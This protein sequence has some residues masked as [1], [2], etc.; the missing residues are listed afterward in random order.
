M[1]IQ[2]KIQ[3]QISE[4]DGDCQPPPIEGAWLRR[5][6]DKHVNTTLDVG[7]KRTPLRTGIKNIQFVYV[8][9]VAGEGSVS[10]Y[11]NLSPD[12]LKF[13]RCVLWFDVEDL[14]QLS[15]KADDDTQLYVY[16]AG[17]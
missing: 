1:A 2:T 17:E 7:K 15:F 14:H 8:R 16:V 6:Y 12:A 13:N 4:R 9:V 10:L 5:S 3:I 11:R